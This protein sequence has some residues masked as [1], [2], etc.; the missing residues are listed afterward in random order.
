M[1]QRGFFG[2]NNPEVENS[3]ATFPLPT[4][5]EVH[6]YIYRKLSKAKGV[7]PSA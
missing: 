2:S 7:P 3:H 4:S 6:K 5:Y 1:N